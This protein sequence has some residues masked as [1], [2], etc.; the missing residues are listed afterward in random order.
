MSSRDGSESESNNQGDGNVEN[1]PPYRE[2][3]DE[4]DFPDDNN[5]QCSDVK[6]FNF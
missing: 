3:R 5:T 6:Q 4:F 2:V 1:S